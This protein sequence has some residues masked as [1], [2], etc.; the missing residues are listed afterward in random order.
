V[1]IFD[2][3]ALNY[4]CFSIILVLLSE[5]EKLMGTDLETLLKTMKLGASND[6]AAKDMLGSDM[7][8]MLNLFQQLV[9]I[10]KR[11]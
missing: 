7:K 2:T 10:K 4:S 8:D 5:F 11:G 9:D 1:K 3:N 6:R